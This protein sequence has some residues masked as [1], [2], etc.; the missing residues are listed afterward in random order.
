MRLQSLV[1]HVT[2]DD[3]R[4]WKE[5][6]LIKNSLSLTVPTRDLLTYKSWKKEALQCWVLVVYSV[7]HPAAEPEYNPVS[8]LA[9][10]AYWCK[11]NLKPNCA[12]PPSCSSLSYIDNPSALLIPWCFIEVTPLYLLDCTSLSCCEIA[13]T[14]QFGKSVY[15]FL[16]TTFF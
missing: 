5:Y 2:Q 3:L 12:A 13:L 4:F 8:P 11:F 16:S 10:T 1:S 9:R 14:A 6:Y 15:L 7:L